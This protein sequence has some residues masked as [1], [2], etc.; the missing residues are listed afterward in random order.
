[1]TN[2]WL[3]QFPSDVTYECHLEENLVIIMFYLPP[4]WGKL[5]ALLVSNVDRPST[6][7][8]EAAS[9]ACAHIWEAWVA[10]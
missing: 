10:S 4:L 9:M 2:L 6:D 3:G 7:Q 1:M 8:S 5:N